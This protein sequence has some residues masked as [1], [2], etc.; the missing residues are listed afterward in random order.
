MRAAPLAPLLLLA[1]PA[2]G[3]TGAPPV[4]IVSP[5]PSA[6]SVTVYRAP[7]RGNE[8][9]ARDNPQGFALISETRTVTLPAGPAVIR[10]EGVAG[11]IFPESAI[12][13]GLPGDVR[14]KN[15]DADLLSPRT[16]YDRALGRRV[17][18]RR[19]NRKTGKVEEEQAIIRSSAAG[20]A[21]LQVAGGQE[22]L[23][24]S[25]LPETIVYDAVPADL[26][27]KPTLSVATDSPVARTVTI[28]LSYLAGGF[29]WQADYVATMGGG[30]G[31]KDGAS[32]DLFAWL[33]LA[34]NDVTSFD[35]ATLQVVAGRLN[36]QSPPQ[37]GAYQAGSLRLSCWPD[38]DYA[39]HR[40]LVNGLPIFTSVPPPP[41]PP[42]P[43]MARAGEMDVVVTGARTAALEQLGDLKLY[44]V[45]DRVTVAAKSEKQVAFL[46]NRGVKVTPLFVSIISYG[47]A[48]GPYL[49]LRTRNT[50]E[51]H[52]GAPLPAGQV[53]VFE[54]AGAR[55]I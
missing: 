42:A 34:S 8:P 53:A 50:P 39:T 21:V 24:C 48:D 41:P 23:R 46:D 17:L 43:M 27:A 33:T 10:F 44:R 47:S 36:R 22:A 32:A 4:S 19:T 11:N 12:I 54:Q 3:Q 1:A 37:F 52:L 55:P 16:L 51:N 45:P 31:G 20:A 2:A 25:G 30:E 14:E 18:I 29:D 35:G 6:V 38:P 49:T 13:T 7:H 26:S 5:A 28:T 15:L 9:I 40:P